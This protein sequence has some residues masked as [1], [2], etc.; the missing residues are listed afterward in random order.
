MDRSSQYMDEPENNGRYPTK[1]E[2]I[3]PYLND[4][5]SY[6]QD[7]HV[8]VPQE[9]Q[10]T[11][12]DNNFHPSQ[13]EQNREQ[14]HPHSQEWGFKPQDEPMDQSPGSLGAFNQT[15]TQSGRPS[16]FDPRSLFSQ[17]PEMDQEGGYTGT[18]GGA[19]QPPTRLELAGVGRHGSLY[20]RAASPGRSPAR[21]PRR[22]GAIHRDNSRHRE[23]QIP[24]EDMKSPYTTD[25][26][27]PGHH[28]HQDGPTLDQGRPDQQR[29]SEV[30][31]Y[32]G[33]RQ[34]REEARV[35]DMG[36]AKYTG[37]TAKPS[38]M[39]HSL[40]G[41]AAQ[42]EHYPSIPEILQPGIAHNPQ[43][44]P[45][46]PGSES[47]RRPVSSSTSPRSQRDSHPREQTS[48]ATGSHVSPPLQQ[49][50][51]LLP[52]E[53]PQRPPQP[54][55]QPQRQNQTAS[56]LGNRSGS[57]QG[58]SPQMQQRVPV[59]AN[60]TRSS[61][62]VHPSAP[63][64][65]PSHHRTDLPS[66]Q[67][68]QP[69]VPRPEKSHSTPYQQQ[70]STPPPMAGP[71]HV[72]DPHQGGAQQ[73]QRQNQPPTM[74][75]SQHDQHPSRKPVP[76]AGFP[77]QPGPARTQ[78]TAAQHP[79]RGHESYRQN[80]LPT[81]QQQQRQPPSRL[82]QGAPSAVPYDNIPRPEGFRQPQQSV[83]GKNSTAPVMSQQGSMQQAHP[84]PLHEVAPSAP[85][86]DLKATARP[87][88]GQQSSEPLTQGYGAVQRVMTPQE[89]QP[90]GEPYRQRQ[91]LTRSP[92]LPSAAMSPSQR[93][94]APA[95]PPASKPDTNVPV[96]PSVADTQIP[97]S[98]SSAQ[99][100]AQRRAPLRTKP[101]TPTAPLTGES[102]LSTLMQGRPAPRL[103][104]RDP[105]N[106]NALMEGP[107]FFVLLY[108][109]SL[110]SFM[111]ARIR[112]T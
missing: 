97:P 17:I 89:Q 4:E 55:L 87:Q 8:A 42:S 51:A 18:A 70:G 59:T 61:Q 67:A 77:S 108:P 48:P 58:A 111:I 66:S 107:C 15:V 9:D 92:P 73:Q 106:G 102:L 47:M 82:K 72:Q 110:V 53:T 45:A 83:P 54:G 56:N 34:P 98:T 75:P 32:G 69:A 63:V 79:P 6:L 26:G 96:P 21:P 91:N 84:P 39:A 93:P 38:N 27:V 44:S 103:D 88:R 86:H 71:R 94:I 101:T 109:N 81:Q 2:I 57:P 74:M 52:H 10:G 37:L 13:E 36:D 33:D 65:D 85:F 25:Q 80:G 20:Y 16:S 35:N 43:A 64:S 68:S 104:A 50:Q 62:G 90:P 22:S 95:R 24:E 23:P 11:H 3:D 29:A 60:T 40:A 76:Q 7:Y 14:R 5:T 31:P 112:D 19:L 1:E 28:G 100:P 78:E 30:S 46:V 99:H 41:Q 12:R 105:K 49:H